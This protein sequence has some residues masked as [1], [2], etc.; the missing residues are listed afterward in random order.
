[1]ATLS[2]SILNMNIGNLKV[3]K[4]AALELAESKLSSAK[5]EFLSDFE[6]HAATKEIEGGKTS[7]NLSGTLNGYGN[8]FT[9]IGFESGSNP[10]EIVKKLIKK[11]RLINRSYKKNKSDGSLISFNVVV[12]SISEFE[13]STPIP[14]ASGRSW[15]IGIERGISGLGFFVFKKGIGRS[16]GGAESENKIRE[17]RYS[18]VSYFTKM[19]N[20]FIKKIKS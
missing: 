11:I 10:T 6:N 4:S 13:K 12:P 20:N 3:I 19:Y 2:T 9:F 7:G 16:G 5:Q 1:M 14:W 18:P 8:L 17:G 15:L